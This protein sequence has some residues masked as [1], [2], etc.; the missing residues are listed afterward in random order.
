M[1]SQGRGAD[2]HKEKVP[3]DHCTCKM[4]NEKTQPS[5]TPGEPTVPTS[6]LNHGYDPHRVEVQVQNVY[7]YPATSA[8]VTIAED[9]SQVKDYVLWSIFS[10]IYLNICCLG[11]AALVHSVKARDRKMVG[12]RN[13]ATTYGSTA[14]K[15][16]IIA[17]SV[18]V[19]WFILI[20]ILMA[21]GVFSVAIRR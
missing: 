3:D 20:I 11:F 15:L 4:D 1:E 5:S 8:V 6:Q 19:C 14:R 2:L 17:T 7:S 13:G 10:A 16:N 9:T 21:T 18:A 12:D